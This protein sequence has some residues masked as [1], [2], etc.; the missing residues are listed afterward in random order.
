MRRCTVKRLFCTLLAMLTLF[1][2]TGTEES[3]PR[4][5]FDDSNNLRERYTD[6][7]PFYSFASSK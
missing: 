4:K 6:R 5:L 1:A 3:R 7:D 2:T